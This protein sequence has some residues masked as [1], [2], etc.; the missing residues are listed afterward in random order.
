MAQQLHIKGQFS[1]GKMWKEKTDQRRQQRSENNVPHPSIED[2][3][4][5]CVFQ[6]CFGHCV[7]I[8]KNAIFWRIFY[9]HFL[10]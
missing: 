5:L 4:S 9:W 8:D 7:F 1:T 3:R 10:L 6:L 2:Q